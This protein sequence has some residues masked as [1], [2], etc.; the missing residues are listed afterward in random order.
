MAAIRRLFMD[1]Q[2]PGS[3]GVGLAIHQGFFPGQFSEVLHHLNQLLR[4]QVF[5]TP[6]TT[7]L[8]H[9]GSNSINLYVL[10]PIGQIH[11]PLWE[12][13]HT[14][15]FQDGQICIGPIQTIQPVTHFPGS[16]FQLFTST[17]H[18]SAHWDFF[19]S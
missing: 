19:P 15:Q 2:P 8:V 12:F 1:P 16:A 5:N 4:H 7:Q 3:A 11:I 18:L 14:I 6:S 17:G 10:G 13:N 9:T